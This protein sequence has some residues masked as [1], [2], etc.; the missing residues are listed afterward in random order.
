MGRGNNG[1]WKEIQAMK[2]MPPKGAKGI[3]LGQ[4]RCVRCGETFTAAYIESSGTALV[5]AGGVQQ[6]H[7]LLWSVCFLCGLSGSPQDLQKWLDEQK[8]AAPEPSSAAAP[9]EMASTMPSEDMPAK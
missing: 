7:K 1:S 5:V 6:Q 9:A 3:V 4:L 2:Q 8:V